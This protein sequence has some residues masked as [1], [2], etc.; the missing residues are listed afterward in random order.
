MRGDEI[1][2]GVMQVGMVIVISLLFAAFV[3]FY[4]E[5]AQDQECKEFMYDLAVCRTTNWRGLDCADIYMEEQAGRCG[6]K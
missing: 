1:E 6:I 4:A 3:W 2:G 5:G